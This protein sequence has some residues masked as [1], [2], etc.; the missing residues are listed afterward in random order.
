[1]LRRVILDN[2]PPLWPA[3]R[4][5]HSAAE[6][7]EAL[8]REATSRGSES[9][10]KSAIFRRDCFLAG[11]DDDVDEE[12]DR[13]RALNRVPQRSERFHDDVFCSDS[14]AR[15]VKTF[16]PSL[17]DGRWSSRAL[18]F[19]VSVLVLLVNLHW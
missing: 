7:R 11:R 16:P 12:G 10:A 3:P 15:A 19:A 2:R 14:V 18:A 8:A 9:A 5:D 1:V 17:D 4:R 13:L 6:L